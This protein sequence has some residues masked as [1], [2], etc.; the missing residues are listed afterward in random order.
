MTFTAGKRLALLASWYRPSA[1]PARPL[2]DSAAL[3]TRSSP[4]ARKL[5]HCSVD[6]Q[7]DDLVLAP[8]EPAQEFIGVLSELGCTSDGGQ[9]SIKLHWVGNQCARV[10]F[11]VGD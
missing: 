7:L 4:K 9:A 2:R 5:R 3:A 6:L 8:A 11:H 1:I 10:T